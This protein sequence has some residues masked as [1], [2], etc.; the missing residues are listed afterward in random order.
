MEALQNLVIAARLSIQRA[1]L[2]EI[3]PQLRAVVFTIAEHDIDIRFYVDGLIN[4]TDAE[5]ASC[6]ET[7][8]IA[9]YE[10]EDTITTRCIR[11]DYPEPIND[12]GIWVY[13][14]RENSID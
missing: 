2:G 4:E 8:V 12:D 5:S 11:L 9:D 10:P 14:R 7:E 6:V 3:F 13:Q 1:L